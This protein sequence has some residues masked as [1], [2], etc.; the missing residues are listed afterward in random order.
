MREQVYADRI[1]RTVLEEAGGTR[2]ATVTVEVGEMLGLTREP[3]A[4]ACSVLSNGTK[5]EGS[6]LSARSSRGSMKCPARGYTCVKSRVGS[7]R[8]PLGA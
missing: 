6:R 2:P 4:F 8:P 5:A 1:L 3:L 7:S